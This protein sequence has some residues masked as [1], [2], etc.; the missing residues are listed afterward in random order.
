MNN[1]G[2][3]CHI[4]YAIINAGEKNVDRNYSP[5]SEIGE[6]GEKFL[7]VKISGSMVL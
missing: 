7:L 2:K 4:L 5:M 6:I 3:S 1:Y